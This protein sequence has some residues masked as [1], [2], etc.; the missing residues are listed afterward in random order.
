MSDSATVTM[1]RKFHRNATKFGRLFIR[2]RVNLSDPTDYGAYVGTQGGQIAVIQLPPGQVDN[3]IEIQDSTGAIPATGKVL[4]AIDPVGNLQ[5]SGVTKASQQVT[6]VTLTAANIIAMFTTPVPILPAPGLIT[7]AILVE[8]IAFELDLT[9]TAFA[10]GGVVH[11]YYHGQTTEIMAQ[12]IAAATVNGGAGQSV[13]LLEPVQ[14]AGGSVIT[15][16]VGID[17]TN[18]T[19]VFATGTGTIKVTVWYSILTLG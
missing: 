17:I 1:A 4:F 2:P 12:T 13:Y 5:Y 3:A 9:A 19:G 15:P 7:Q 8:Q 11:F 10:S 14:T 6:Q 18:L 16:G